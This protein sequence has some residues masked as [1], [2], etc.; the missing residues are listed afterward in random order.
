MDS[1]DWRLCV[2][3]MIDVTD[4]HCRFFHRLLAPRARLY[5]EMI[6]T[7]ALQHGNIPRH[8]DFDEAEHPVALQLGGS[9]PDAL[10]QSA[11]LG[12]Q[13]G[14]DEINLNCGCPSE[15]VQKGAFGA[16]L[17]AE[18]DLVADCIK[19]MQDAVDIPVTVKHRLGLDYENSYDFV[20]DFVGK[21]YDTGCR[22]FIAHARNAVLKGLTP[23]DNREIPPLRYDV[24]KQLKRD[25]P[26]C[27]FVLNG[28]LADADQ[29]VQAA[30]EFD[31]VML[32]RAAWHTPRV[33]SEVSL[34]LWPSVRLPSDAQVVD[35][36]TEY[37]A[38]QVAQGVPLRVMTR[39][40]L[41]LVNGQSGARR[42]R[43]MLSD[44]ALLSANNPELIYDAWRSQRQAPDVR[45][46]ALEA[47]PA[48]V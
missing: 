10:A 27:T 34:R 29:S 9:E 39:P 40:M 47:A 18:P 32:G 33:L 7:G 4:R 24:V 41:G 21:I 3:P 28:G 42:W 14:Y 44:P 45:G 16:C 31:G 8:L 20:R 5:T 23:K 6:T 37:A 36:M 48:G 2:A 15:R 35:A 19:A 46:A 38:R 30:G 11:K 1:P 22:V 17:M 25:F 13:W 43:R 26:D 12:R